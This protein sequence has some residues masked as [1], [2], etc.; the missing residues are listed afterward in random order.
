[1]EDYLILSRLSVFQQVGKILTFL[2]MD[3]LE[4][5]ASWI[6]KR[7]IVEDYLPYQVINN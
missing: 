3:Q 7:K 5:I 6:M 4:K 2:F 1:M